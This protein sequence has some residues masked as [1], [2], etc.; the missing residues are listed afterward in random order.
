MLLESKV[1]EILLMPNIVLLM[2]EMGEGNDSGGQKPNTFG[3]TVSFDLELAP[4]P[5]RRTGR[6]LAE[7]VDSSEHDSDYNDSELI[8]CPGCGNHIS[9]S[10]WVDS[11]VGFVSGAHDFE[12]GNPVRARIVQTLKNEA[13]RMNVPH[14]T[15]NWE[16]A[17]VSRLMKEIERIVQAEINRY[18]SEHNDSEQISSVQRQEIESMTEERVRS[19]MALEIREQVALEI[20]PELEAQL[21]QEIEQRL[22]SEFEAEWKKR[23]STTS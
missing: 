19:S 17:I 7:E 15:E 13:S 14:P 16:L 23:S 20:I 10:D 9:D 4:A 1:G 8:G 6:K 5:K 18:H 22:W 12:V 3:T 2:I 11:L 21:R